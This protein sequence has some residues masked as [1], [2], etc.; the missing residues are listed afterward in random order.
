VRETTWSHIQ[1]EVTGTL[2]TAE[3][4]W[5]NKIYKWKQQY[6]DQVDIKHINEDK[7]IVVHI[8][9][10]WFKV[11]PTKRVSEKNKIAAKERMKNIQASRKSNKDNNDNSEDDDDDEDDDDEYYA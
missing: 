2:Y 6:P 11:S 5:I 1:G 10:K 7:S 9:A 4:K 3:N 8:P